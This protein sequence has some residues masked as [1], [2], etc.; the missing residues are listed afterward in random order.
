MPKRIVIENA[1]RCPFCGCEKIF[2]KACQTGAYTKS[3]A[4]SLQCSRCHVNGPQVHG[5]ESH[6]LPSFDKLSESVRND[7]IEQALIKWN[8]RFMGKMI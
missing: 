5:K 7:L 8:T 3:F 6:N 1:D 4:V 2:L